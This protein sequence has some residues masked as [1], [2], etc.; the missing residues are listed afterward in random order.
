MQIMF[1]HGKSKTDTTSSFQIVS[2][3]QNAAT[4]SIVSC[5]P[6]GQ[7]AS[8]VQH[9]ETVLYVRWRGNSEADDAPE[10]SMS[11]LVIVAPVAYVKFDGELTAYGSDKDGSGTS[12]LHALPLG[13]SVRA[14][15]TAHDAL[16]RRF[17]ALSTPI[18]VRAHRFDQVGL[19][20]IEVWF[21]PNNPCFFP[22]FF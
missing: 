21:S 4:H 14:H 8:G 5:S 15:V 22:K 18:V 10:Q 17:H 20:R 1:S 2:I 6:E 11:L 12:S 13:A 3:D 7:I 9:G 19:K 16:G